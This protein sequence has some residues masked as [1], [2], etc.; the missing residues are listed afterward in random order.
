MS[1]V[2]ADMFICSNGWWVA[3]S[4]AAW[5]APSPPRAQILLPPWI[6]AERAAS[7]QRL[8]MGWRSLM[9]CAL[10][11]LLQS[12]WGRAPLG[13]WS[14]SRAQAP[15]CSRTVLALL[16]LPSASPF[17]LVIGG[18]V[19]VFSAGLLGGDAPPVDVVGTLLLLV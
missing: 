17:S 12:P 1:W 16:C 2:L 7:S 3:S 15:A 18:D 14:V 4:W 6:P 5:G 8:P 10:H 19:N 11:A 9:S 13:P